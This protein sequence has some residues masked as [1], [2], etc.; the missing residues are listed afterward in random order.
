MGGSWGV[1]GFNPTPGERLPSPTTLMGGWGGDGVW[2]RP[3]F[4]GGMGGGLPRSIL[5][6]VGD[7]RPMGWPR[8]PGKGPPSEVEWGRPGRRALGPPA[9]GLVKR[10]RTCV[11]VWRACCF[12]A[13]LSRLVGERS[14]DGGLLWEAVPF[15]SC[16]W[17]L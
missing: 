13:K 2:E 7:L 4:L 9:G 6:T 17:N 15:W 11:T 10:E 14:R 12:A 5:A 8:R 3:G 1:A 16:S